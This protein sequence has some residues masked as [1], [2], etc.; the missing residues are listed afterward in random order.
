MAIGHEKVA[1]LISPP[2]RLRTS[3]LF[4]RA[5]THTILMKL[6][7]LATHTASHNIMWCTHCCRLIREVRSR[8]VMSRLTHCLEIFLAKPHT[9]VTAHNGLRN[10]RES[11]IRDANWFLLSRR[12][13]DEL[14][15]G[16]HVE[17]YTPN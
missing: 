5:H 10:C 9:A 11:R 6:P 17:P 14:F 13:R 16:A 1:A 15:I 3:L 7:N 8:A 12:G 2:C 4:A